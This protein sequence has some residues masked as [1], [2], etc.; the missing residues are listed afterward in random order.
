[1]PEEIAAR[2]SLPV[3][4]TGPDGTNR[5]GCSFVVRALNG[6]RWLLMPAHLAL[7]GDPNITK[8]A[9]DW[10][11]WVDKISLVYAPKTCVEIPLFEDTERTVPK[12]RFVGTDA[13]SDVV[14]MWLPDSSFDDGGLLH[15]V[16]VVDIATIYKNVPG[17]TI[18]YGYPPRSGGVWPYYPPSSASGEVLTA[19]SPFALVTCD[20]A[21]ENS[22]GY[23][24]APV[25][26]GDKLA[27][28]TIGTGM[29]MGTDQAVSLL[30]PAWYIFMLINLG[31][32]FSSMPIMSVAEYVA[33]ETRKAEAVP[34]HIPRPAGVKLRSALVGALNAGLITVGTLDVDAVI[35][36]QALTISDSGMNL[37][38]TATGT[39]IL[40]YTDIL[41]FT[42]VGR[43]GDVV[44]N[45]RFMFKQ[46]GGS[47]ASY[48]SSKF[49]L[50][51]TFLGHDVLNYPAGPGIPFSTKCIDSGAGNSDAAF[52]MSATYHMSLANGATRTFKLRC[53][54]DTDSSTRQLD[55]VN[56]FYD[57]TAN[58]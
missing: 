15:G 22:F 20:Y 13:I 44:I 53:Y 29:I 31:G 58:H 10:S 45:V 4:A 34:S 43:G 41:T 14:A 1:M 18:C 9:N 23:S 8:L 52:Q 35:T 2:A 50:V 48:T 7:A 40:N 33:H 26:A 19:D 56:A 30:I 25:F 3:Y 49:E 54:G 28:M 36:H 21:V 37:G 51:D 27:G 17:S 39:G 46:H 12:F 38:P 11:L 24:G 55:I 5:G 57:W 6:S 16:Q 42:V 47:S 32:A